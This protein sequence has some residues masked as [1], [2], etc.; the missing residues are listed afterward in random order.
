MFKLLSHHFN[1]LQ[2]HLHR[3]FNKSHI[4]FSGVQNSLISASQKIPYHTIVDTTLRESF[5]ENLAQFQKV[6]TRPAVQYI[7][8]NTIFPLF[9]YDASVTPLQAVIKPITDSL[10]QVLNAARRATNETCLADS[11]I[12]LSRFQLLYNPTLKKIKE[13]VTSSLIDLRTYFDL[14]SNAHTKAIGLATT[15]VNE[16]ES[17]TTADKSDTAASCA[18]KVNPYLCVNLESKDC[19]TCV[20]M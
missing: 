18:A 20:A 9:D 7:Q 16:V 12:N 11:Y 10:D 19:E 17:C 3:Q 5:A 14:L 4:V 13:C 15:L 8:D 6:C 1:S 2:D